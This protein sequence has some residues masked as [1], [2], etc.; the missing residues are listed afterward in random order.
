M[1]LQHL[2]FF[3]ATLVAIAFV[4]WFKAQLEQSL[5]KVPVRRLARRPQRRR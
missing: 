3:S 4:L 2:Q 1:T 5:A